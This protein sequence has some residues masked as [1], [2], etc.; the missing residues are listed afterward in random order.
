MRFLETIGITCVYHHLVDGTLHP[1]HETENDQPPIG[2][3]R[4]TNIVPVDKSA[5]KNVICVC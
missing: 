4:W 5:R 1:E 3:M 2:V